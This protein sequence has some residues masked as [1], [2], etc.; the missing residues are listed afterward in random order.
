[1]K[2]MSGD[3]FFR[4]LFNNNIHNKL[5]AIKRT[6]YRGNIKTAKKAARGNHR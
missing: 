3:A 4:T 5:R 2:L 6:L 1:M